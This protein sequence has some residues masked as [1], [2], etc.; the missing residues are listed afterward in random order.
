MCSLKASRVAP[1]E[2]TT[3]LVTAAL[4]TTWLSRSHR[5]GSPSRRVDA[6]HAIGP[7]LVKTM[8]VPFGSS[9]AMARSSDA[10]TRSQ[11]WAK[12]SS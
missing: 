3:K 12:D 11:K 6:A 9:T 7:P 2:P 5:C 1:R 8:A 10:E 4:I